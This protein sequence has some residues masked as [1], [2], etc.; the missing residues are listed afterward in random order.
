MSDAEEVSKRAPV[1]A[2]GSD[3]KK[4]LEAEE[5]VKEVEAKKGEGAKPSG[6]SWFGWGK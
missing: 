3:E 2:D 5:V 1:Y 4:R 6:G